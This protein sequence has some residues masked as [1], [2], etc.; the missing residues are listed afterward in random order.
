MCP[1]SRRT[2]RT[3]EEEEKAR[4]ADEIWA[5]DLK[6]VVIG[7]STYYLLNFLDEYSRLIVHH[8]LLWSMDG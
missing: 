7:G 8:E 2:K 3:R 1:W 4:R 6:Y 5:T